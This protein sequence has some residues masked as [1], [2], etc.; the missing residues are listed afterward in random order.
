MNSNLEETFYKSLNEP[1]KSS[2][3]QPDLLSP[4]SFICI[5]CVQF[6]MK[7]H[8]FIA[9]YTDMFGLLCCASQ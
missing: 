6:I 1:V 4:D 9:C 2:A 7:L 3:D 5:I 8:L